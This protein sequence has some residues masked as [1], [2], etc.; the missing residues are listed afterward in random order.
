MEQRLKIIVGEDKGHSWELPPYGVLNLGRSR[1]HN[2]ICIHDAE[3]ARIHCQVEIDNHRVVLTDLDSETGTYVNGERITQCQLQHGDVVRVGNT[4]LSFLSVAVKAQQP[5]AAKAGAS[6]QAL[7]A[8]A[9]E[10]PIEMELAEAS[11]KSARAPAAGRPSSKADF[12]MAPSK[13]DFSMAPSK[14]DFPLEGLA[15][16]A[17]TTFGN[18]EL[19]PTLARGHCAVLF[20]A[21]SLKED[22]TVALKV[23]HTEFPKTEAEMQH[24]VETM[25]RAW[26]IRHSHL[27]TI[28]GIG[29]TG[30]HAWIAREFVEGGSVAQML[31]KKED[32]PRPDWKQAFRLAVHVGR[33]LYAVHEHHLLHRNLTPANILYRT[34][35]HTFKLTDVGLAKALT[36]TALRQTCLRAKVQA[37]LPYLATEQTHPDGTLDQRTDLYC[38]GAVVYALVAG[39]PP[40][41][42]QNMAETIAMIREAELLPPREHQPDLPEAFEAAVLKLLAKKPDDRFQTAGELL[43]ELAQI[44]PDPV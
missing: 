41:I 24:F 20:R 40:F 18:Y 11:P 43:A 7:P 21:R 33:A 28:F 5:A 35:D 14:V 42:G 8:D 31:R 19:G 39:G 38:L 4:Q 26:P 27:V 44:F 13:A 15:H 22:R 37:E 29:R 30:P 10:E 23:L 9:D 1:Q 36:G 2:E 25:K 12:S 32:T 17:N 3:L 34:T 6:S 16:L